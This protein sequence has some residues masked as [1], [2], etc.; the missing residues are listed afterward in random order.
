MLSGTLFKVPVL[1]ILATFV[2]I[3]P[4]AVL[5]INLQEHAVSSLTFGGI[6]G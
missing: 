5:I 3:V 4:V 6:K 1:A 2:G